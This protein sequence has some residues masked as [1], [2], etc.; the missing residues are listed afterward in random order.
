M[1]RSGCWGGRGLQLSH[2]LPPLLQGECL[3]GQ[4]R[5]MLLLTV[6][7]GPE[8]SGLNSR[9]LNDGQ[10]PPHPKVSPRRGFPMMDR[11]SS[12]PRRYPMGI[13]H[14]GM[15]SGMGLHAGKPPK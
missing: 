8:E 4:V 3:L 5:L 14:T 12:L 7:Y 13:S 10:A 11:S 6:G 2:I 1:P 9:F 15:I